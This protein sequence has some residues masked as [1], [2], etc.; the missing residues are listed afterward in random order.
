[1]TLYAMGGGLIEVLV[2]PIVEACPTDKKEAAMSLL[3][4]FY[5]WGHVAVVLVSTAFFQLAGIGN[6][7]YHGLPVGGFAAGQCALFFP[8]PHPPR[9]G[10]PASAFVRSLFGQKLFLAASA[11][12]GLRRSGGAGMSQWASVFA[13]SGLGVSKTIG[14]LA[15]P[16]GFALL[17]GTS[18]ALYE[19]SANACRC[20]QQ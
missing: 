13:E 17:M 9:G 15:G 20:A 10:P 18:R 19:N 8:G 4:S 14:D 6:W 7:A 11:D 2:S 5:C 16:C 1:M 3:H 12:D